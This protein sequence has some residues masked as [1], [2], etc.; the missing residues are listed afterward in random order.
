MAELC[1]SV[2]ASRDTRALAT[3]IARSAAGVEGKER[4]GNAVGK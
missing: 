4:I 3:K 2:R 1:L